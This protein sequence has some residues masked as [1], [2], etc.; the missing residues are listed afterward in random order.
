[1]AKEPDQTRWVGVRPTDPAENIPVTESSPV[2]EVD[3]N[4][5]AGC[6]NFPV[7]ESA[8]LTDIQVAPSAGNPQFE[9]VTQKRAPAVA[10][11]QAIESFV[12]IYQYRADVGAP[13]YNHDIYTVPAGKIFLLNYIY[14][15]CLQPDPTEIR[16]ILKEGANDFV[17]YLEPYGAAWEYHRR[18][19][20][21]LYNEDEIVRIRWIGTAALNDVG[22]GIFGHLIDRY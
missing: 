13:D 4:P 5:A 10:D 7:T 11:L 15:F 19:P 18:T 2:T 22:G 1:M 6:D 16:F 20:N 9:T 14:A 17:W 8:P 21:V 3:V 12:R